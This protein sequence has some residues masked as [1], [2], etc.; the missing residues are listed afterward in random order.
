MTAGKQPLDSAAEAD[1]DGTP[2][3]TEMT[4]AFT[5]KQLFTGFAILAGFV[6]F[7]RRLA[8]RRGRG[9]AGGSI[10]EPRVARDA[11]ES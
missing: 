4:V 5:P 1:A 10:D 9:G 7:V 2:T 11:D 3:A 8:R 6:L